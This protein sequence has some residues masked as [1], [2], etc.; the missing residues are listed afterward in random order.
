[1]RN[2][3]VYDLDR[4]A[5][6][7][8]ESDALTGYTKIH[9]IVANDIKGNEYVFEAPTQRPR[10]AREF[11]EFIREYNTVVGH[12]FISFD[13]GCLN[14]LLPG[15]LPPDIAVLDTLV[16]SRLVNYNRRGGHSIAAWGETF[17]I[18]KEG[19]DIT[20]WSVYTE[21]MLRR[22]K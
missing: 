4:L 2:P 12:N 15:A 22:C 9:T 20:N 6:V 7:D 13:F 3:L 19:K 11:K 14:D 8:V 17:G 1:M 21:E 10:I 18:K 16:V 5:V